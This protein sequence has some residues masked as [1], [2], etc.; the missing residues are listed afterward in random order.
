M[1]AAELAVASGR[2]ALAP[3]AATWAGSDA[4]AP[5]AE[6]GP[7]E[8]RDA[9][10][11]ALLMSVSPTGT[12]RAL[13]LSRTELAA[14]IEAADGSLRID[15]YALPA[16]TLLASTAVSE[17]TTPEIDMAGK[18]IVYRV[19]RKIRL[20]GPQGGSRLLIQ[21]E[22]MPIN[23]SIEGRRVAWAANGGGQHRIRALLVPR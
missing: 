10:S 22:N 17:R 23:V 15:R 3:A 14:L 21:T 9:A 6:N 13:A 2:I 4:T 11:G 18:W 1:P 12:V 8:V 7:I 16:G 19:S 5:A 20:I